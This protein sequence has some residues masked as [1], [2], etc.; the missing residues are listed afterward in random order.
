MIQG[1]AELAERGR[2]HRRG[3]VTFTAAREGCSA[4]SNAELSLLDGLFRC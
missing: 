1:Y 3:D 2:S 4:H